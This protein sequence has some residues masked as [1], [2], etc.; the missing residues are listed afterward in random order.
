MTNAAELPLNKRGA[1]YHLDLLAEE[2]SDTIITVGDPARVEQ[3][4]RHFDSIDIQRS[5]RE[6]V[7]NT[8]NIGKKRLTVLSTGIGMPNVEIVMNELDALASMDLSTR[9][10]LD[11]GR[12]LT[13]IRLGTTGSIHQDFS[14]GDIVNSA[15]AIGLDN[16]M[17]FYRY[18][19]TSKEE[20]LYRICR[21][22]VPDYDSA[23]F[24]AQAEETLHQFFKSM[25]KP[26]ITITCNGFY[27][28]QGRA[29][30]M[31]LAYPN[32]YN[33]ITKISIDSIPV[34][35]IEMETA[36]LYGLSRLMGHRA[37]SL[38]V[39]L[40]NRVKGEFAEA[41]DPL[42]DQMIERALMEITENL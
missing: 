3:I 26:G 17:D 37:V 16:M 25:A 38:S 24:I 30:R 8:G 33:D 23:L 19:L 32:L 13:L 6:F 9:T 15:Y 20:Q 29:V 11:K 18:N 39:V 12:H 7:T 41:I 28:A 2:I 1:V 21:Q 35:N 42:V 22:A 10:A 5:H 34:I 27:A 4:S 31:P 14:I 40:A 36:A